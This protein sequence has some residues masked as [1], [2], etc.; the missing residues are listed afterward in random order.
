MDSVHACDPLDRPGWTLHA[1]A[2]T[3][4]LGAALAALAHASA[5]PPELWSTTLANVSSHMLARAL[6]ATAFCAPGQT[7][8]LVRALYNE[9]AYVGAHALPLLHTL[10]LK[11]MAHGLLAGPLAF[12][13]IL[14]A[15]QLPHVALFSLARRPGDPLVS[16][17]MPI[18]RAGRAPLLPPAAYAAL[19]VLLARANG[20]RYFT[21]SE[22][23]TSGLAA[24]T[25]DA[26]AL[27]RLGV[28]TQTVQTLEMAAII[29]SIVDRWAT[30][31]ELVRC[32]LD[33][34]SATRDG[35]QHTYAYAALVP[36]LAALISPSAA[37]A[38]AQ[39]AVERL[40]VLP[41]YASAQI[42]VLH[43]KALAVA[44]APS[45]H[46]LA[47]R[48]AAFAHALASMD[49]PDPQAD[50]ELVPMRE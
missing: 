15:H 7:G 3:P 47:R 4:E 16:Q 12:A 41:E 32:A 2:R 44:Q 31:A 42:A 11:H 24:A 27:L 36:A 1:D 20:A 14:R 5:Q 21:T 30:F 23:G 48:R 25:D 13:L 18:M 10:A 28:G 35:T 17:P 34:G 26:P 22:L 43:E 9:A 50:D 40:A 33:A 38:L 45:A 37:P 39:A 46:E 19:D 6:A 8:A 49:A 29:E